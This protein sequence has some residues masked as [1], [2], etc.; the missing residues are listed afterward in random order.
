MSGPTNEKSTK[1]M[2]MPKPITARRLFMNSRSASRHPLWTAPMSPPSGA[3]WMSSG[4]RDDGV[5][6]TSASSG[7]PDARVGDGERDIRDQVSDDHQDGAR[8]RVGEQH[9]VVDLLQALE[10]EQSQALE[11]EQRLG[12]QIAGQQGRQGQP[13]QGHH[14]QAGVAD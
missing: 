12:D 2:S 6:A 7:Q 9:R 3:R 8:Q 4:G 1:K 14:R 5:V 13:D 11:V 10:E